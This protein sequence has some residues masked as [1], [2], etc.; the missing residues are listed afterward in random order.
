MIILSEQYG[1]QN[2]ASIDGIEAFAHILKNRNYAKAIHK[3]ENK[4]HCYKIYY[5]EG[6]SN[7]F[8]F[9]TSYFVG[10]DW[11]V[12][13]ILPIYVK[14]K[15]DNDLSEVNYLKMLFDALREPENYGHLDGLC[16][17]SFEKP[18]IPVQ[19]SDD[20]LTPLLVVQYLNML[21]KIVQK[22]LKK[23][24]YT[25]TE[26]LN[27]T[28]KGRILINETIK[29]NHF[30][31]K[32][33][34]SLCMSTAFGTNNIENRLLKKALKFSIAAIGNID[35]I[36]TSKLK[37]LVNYIKPVFSAVGD[38]VDIDDLKFVRP[39]KL[40]KEYDQALRLGKSILKRFGYNISNVN[41]KIINTPPF[42]ID[43]SKLFELYVFAKLKERFPL[44]KEVSYHKKFNYLEPD[45]IIKSQDGN[46]KM[47]VDAK[48]KP[49]Y[50]NGSI[51]I[52]DIRQ[53]SA[54]A[55]LK[56]IYEF[57]DVEKDK[58]IDCLVVYSSQETQRLDF[59]KHNFIIEA[60]KDYMQFF[61]IGIRLPV[62]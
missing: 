20:L 21:K 46:V 50:L 45:F 6:E 56:K 32:K 13:N 58:I 55:R 34:F 15:L 41:S 22:G 14:P 16:E 10:I 28:V 39:N 57:L 1:Y 40:Y 27:S 7:P 54:Y 36:N 52:E 33:N 9:E 30:N 49:Y 11:V 17:I 62:K 51:N 23:S 4:A 25:V 37:E 19:Q 5:K 2:P 24:Y 47:V 8:T 29:K 12:E 59:K 53:I 35:G 26:N 61:K 42:W 3:G 48:Y 38:E 43:M 31:N 44:L 60:E 18:A